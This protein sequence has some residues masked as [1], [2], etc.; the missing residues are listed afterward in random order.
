MGKGKTKDRTARWAN[1]E[2]L[3]YQY[4][5]GL[6]VT[7]IANICDVSERQIYR[8]INDLDLKLHIPIWGEHGL[9]GIEDGYFLPPIRLSAPEALNI[10]LAAR[11]ML[12]YANRYDPSIASTFIKLNSIVPTPLREEVRTTLDWMQKLPMNEK[13]LQ[14]MATMAEAWITRRQVRIAYRALE[15]EKATER[16][17]EPYFIE[18][19]AAGHSCYIIAYCRLTKSLRTFKVERID[20]A[21]IISETYVIPVEFDANTFFGS[22]LG[23]VVEG[24]VETI[25]LKFSPDI[26]RIIEET[27]WHPSQLVEKQ[28]DG[29]VIMTLRVTPTIDLYNFVLRWGEKVE[30]LEPEEL[31]QDIIETA[32]AMLDVYKG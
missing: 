29:S 14:I 25:S 20:A 27:A 9:Y 22:S 30:V 6:K 28:S 4:P 1:I 17:I 11:L 24:D 7:E 8:D 19:A 16:L 15:A 3:L 21:E 2:H 26:A 5:K 23:I 13:Y 32:K 18:P 10:F 12:N 31:R